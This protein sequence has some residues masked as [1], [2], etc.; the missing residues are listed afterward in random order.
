MSNYRTHSLFHYTEKSNSLLDIIKSGILYPNF[1]EEDLSTKKNPNYI[2]G[3]PQI[4]F[5]DIPISLSISN[6]FLEQYGHYAIAFDK[7]WGIRKR[8]NPIQYVSNETIIDGVIHYKTR[9][10]KLHADLGQRIAIQGW[11]SNIS[12]YIKYLEDIQAYIYLIGFLKKY[13]GEWKGEPYC[14][15]NE[16]EWRFI[17]PDGFNKIRWKTGQ[18]YDKWR[19]NPK[20]PKPEP[21]IE[22]KKSGLK[23]QPN[24]I[25][26]IILKKEEEIPDFIK[27][28]SSIDK[29]GNYKLSD[30]TKYSLI[31]KITSFER[32][33]KDF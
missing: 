6:A 31:S 15:Y 2:L 27:E 29:V 24:N 25:T 23:F 14:N 9:M 7:E 17:I 32:I 1:C 13:N 12:E 30:K 18:E 3:I 22:L 11:S 19:G 10:R 5:C 28:L 26:H 16:N 4:C 8:C 20:Q 21:T 33:S